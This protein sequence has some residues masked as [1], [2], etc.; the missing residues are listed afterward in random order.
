VLSA[1]LWGLAPLISGPLAGALYDWAGPG[2]VFL[3]CA[4]AAVV[5]GLVLILAQVAGVF[6]ESAET[7]DQRPVTGDRRLPTIPDA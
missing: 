5:A 4:G 1:G 3:A 7:G 6:K 2:A